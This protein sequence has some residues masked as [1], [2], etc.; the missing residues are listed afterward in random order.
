M[1]NAGGNPKVSCENT[2]K[3]TE[4]GLA[5]GTKLHSLILEI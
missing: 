1:G 4:A 5:A 2:L 3:A